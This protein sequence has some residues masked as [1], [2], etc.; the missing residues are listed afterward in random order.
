MKYL[1]LAY[2]V[3]ERFNALSEK[4]LAAVGEQCKAYDVV[5]NATGKVVGGGSLGW[6]SKSLR[7]KGGKLIVTDGPFV[8]TKEVVG[9]L[10]IIEADDFDE[11]VRIASLHPAAQMDDDLGM[12]IELRPLEHCAALLAADAKSGESSV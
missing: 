11:A 8:D 10:V 5:L 7:R 1:L 9:G 3:E 4:E 12:G 2:G 6:A